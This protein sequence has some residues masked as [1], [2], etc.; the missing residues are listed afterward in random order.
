MAQHTSEVLPSPP[1]AEIKQW[2][3][4]LAPP[5]PGS[6]GAG[7]R[8]ATGGRMCR[9]RLKLFVIRCL[10]VYL[11]SHGRLVYPPV[12]QGPGW[13]AW[14]AGRPPGPVVPRPRPSEQLK[15]ELVCVIPS[16]ERVAVARR[17]ECHTVP[18]VRTVSSIATLNRGHPTHPFACGARL[19]CRLRHQRRG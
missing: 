10:Y 6:P 13:R 9:F 18:T 17:D 11:T 2:P 14:R 19:F 5:P 16:R 3:P 12:G 8:R 15:Q 1:R 4:N 7:R